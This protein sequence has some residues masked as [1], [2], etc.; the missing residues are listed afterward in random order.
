MA[1]IGVRERRVRQVAV[2]GGGAA[3]VLVVASLL[4]RAD[5]ENPVDIHLIERSPEFGPGLAYRTDFPLHTLNNF[6]GRMSAV[7]DDPDHFVRWSEANGHDITPLSF[8]QRGVYGRYLAEVLDT[9]I[10]PPGSTLTRVRGEVVNVVPRE[11]AFEVWLAENWPV[12]AESVVLAL[13]TPPAQIPSGYDADEIVD[14]WDAE[15]PQRLRA[16]SRAL[17]VGAGLTMVD[18]AALAQT[19]NPSLDL[20]AV[21][22]TG[23]LPRTHVPRALR[24]AAG[25]VPHGH[26]LDEIAASVCAKLERTRREGG[27]WRDVIEAVRMQALPLWQR[28]NEQDRKRFLEEYSRE[29]ETRRHRMTPDM[30]GLIDALISTGALRVARP[31][32]V[33]AEDFDLVVNCTG[34]GSFAR[35]GWNPLVDR[36]LD[37]G[38]VRSHALGLGI[39]VD[40]YGQVVDR[41]GFAV[42]RLYAVGA[43]RKGVEWE[44]TAVPD[45]RRHASTLADRLLARPFT[46]SVQTA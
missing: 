25:F 5:E 29:W 45:L 1:E 7:D 18:V 35:P 30:G 33:D 24:D 42:P 3:G 15:L 12:V 20:V 10:V 14:A 32:E 26:T 38:V 44:S 23:R 40:H 4:R 37:A 41:A 21:S 2:V 27:D 46:S 39:D 36:L 13:G 28:L 43:A 31:S 16:A 19:E 17:L 9:L 11:G 8:A 34:L 6:A 22:R